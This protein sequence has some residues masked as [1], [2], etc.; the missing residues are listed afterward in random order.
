MAAL[1]ILCLFLFIFSQALPALS[2]SVHVSKT[3]YRS[4]RS[5]T[6][7][8]GL[9]VLLVQ[10]ERTNKAAAAIALPV[11]NLDDPDSQLGLAHYLEHML[12][13]GSTAY[14]EPAGLQ[15]FVN[16]H[17]GSTNA[18]TGYTSTIY[19]LEVDV[20]A[21]AEGL[22]RMADTLAHPLLDAV[23]ADKERNAVHAEMES[24]KYEDGR[25]L[26][27]LTLG[28][29]NPEHPVTRFSGGNLETLSDKPQS[30]LQEELVRFHQTW[31]CAGLMKAV[32]Y[33]PQSLNEL[34]LL[35]RQALCII[36]NRKA[37]LAVPAVP[38]VTDVEQGVVIGMRPVRQA[39]SITLEFILPKDLDRY[40]TKPVHIVAAVLG[41]ETKD[42]LVDVLRNQG[43]VL[44][45]SVGA[46]ITTLRNG[47]IM[48][49]SMELTEEGQAKRDKILSTVFSYLDLLRQE[50]IGQDYFD[51]YQR[52]MDMQ[53][54]YAPVNS[55]FGYVYQ[56]AA[57]MLEYPVED[58]HFGPYRLDYF[59]R[60][61]VSEV[62]DFLTP[63]RA[64]IFH[65]GEDQPVDREAYFYQTPYSVR[66]VD[67]KDFQTWAKE[68]HQLRLPHLNPFVPDDFSLVTGKGMAI[69]SKLVD[70]PGLTVWHGLSQFHEEPKAILMAR[71]QSA[72]FASSLE[73]VA[74]QGLLV[75][76]LSQTQ[77]GLRYQ[78]ME[79]G[80]GLS[81]F[82]DEG[83]VVNIS[84][85]SQHQGDLLIT[86]LEFLD[87]PID[88][89]AFVQAKT[90]YLRKL[91]NQEKQ[92]V[93]RQA[94]GVMSNLLKP[95][96]WDYRTI[97][98]TAQEISRQDLDDYLR[99][100]RQD[101]RF[102]VFGFGNITPDNLKDLSV[103]LQK[104]VGPQAGE[105]M[106][107]TRILPK[108]DL[109]VAYQ[110]ETELED[111]ALL[112]L[113]LAPEPTSAMKAKVLVLEGLLDQRFFSRLRTEEQLGYVA[114]T[115]PVMF[116][117]AVGIGFGVQSPVQGTSGLG[118]RFN[119]FYF[120]GLGQMR[121]VS[122]EEF[123]SVRQGL[124]A[125]ITRPP[126]TLNAEFGV[127]ET[128]LRLGNARF[129]SQKQLVDALQQVTLP[130]VVRTYE[131]LVLGR[132][133]TQVTIEVQGARHGHQPW[134]QN[135]WALTITSPQDF[136]E[137]V[138]VQRYRGL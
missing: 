54:E 79:A 53:F 83:L 107:A 63:D 7:D 71:L 99:N 43:L 16:R 130:Q 35:A 60:E 46:D 4:F 62:L 52:I 40:E 122:I 26:A 37:V 73:Q 48:S 102:T 10:D 98:Q 22:Q 18:A 103:C 114:T 135:P 3:E 88:E 33:G 100:V 80:L 36:P 45:L 85:F 115:M 94:M 119:S 55:G 76:L 14:P 124:L 127:L 24:K 134:I 86:A 123:E 91:A 90:E 106:I 58:V 120:W 129:N 9:E 6:L 77:S 20:P 138:D 5:L 17:G 117:Q 64:R 109:G 70:R 11:G 21:F 27:M 84:G 8:S 25:R 50:G 112:E 28:T 89:H 97:A 19:V 75:E 131:T 2:A 92:S 72:S 78:A 132:L 29:M 137:L 113:F 69:P 95:L 1:R 121:S 126:D 15:A 38:A 110:R 34:E 42:S 23:Y 82:G 49:L 74:M 13:L 133:G 47:I 93:F 67:Q 96:S 65:V 108:K 116:G 31:Y 118:D 125:S 104:Y 59:D 56:A 66:S 111:S 136:H 32:L 81:I 61:A 68:P 51:Q 57:N 128:D 101:L 30:I 12:F 39:H 105:P 41:T 87:Q 44:G